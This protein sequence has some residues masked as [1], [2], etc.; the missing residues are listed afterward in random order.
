MKWYDRAAGSSLAPLT[1][2]SYFTVIIMMV[3]IM[4]MELLRASQESSR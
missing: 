1:L 3:I 4:F 2:H